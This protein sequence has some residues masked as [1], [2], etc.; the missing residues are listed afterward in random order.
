[1]QRLDFTPRDLWLIKKWAGG[2]GFAASVAAN[3]QK[4]GWISAKQRT[5][6]ENAGKPK[7]PR[8]WGRGGNRQQVDYDFDL[9]GDFDVGAYELCV[10]EW[11]D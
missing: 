7:A 11:G 3:V 8:G 1:M 6:L 5:V 9:G 4:Q 10:G 2:M